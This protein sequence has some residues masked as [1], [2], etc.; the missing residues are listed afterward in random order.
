MAFLE[1]RGIDKRFGATVALHQAALSVNSGEVHALI[2]ENGSGKSTLMKVLAGVVKADGGEIT[3]DGQPYIP[4][5]PASARNA[6]ISMIHQEL[7]LCND[8]NVIENI[9]LGVERTTGVFLNQKEQLDIAIS[10]LA[11]LGQEEVNP[12]ARVGDLP[13]ATRQMIEIARSLAVG[14]QVLILDEPTS[15]LT[16]SDVSKLFALIESLKEQNLA[17]IYISHFFDEIN[18]ISDVFTVLRDGE[19]TGTGVT[20]DVPDEEIISMMVGREIED[21]YPHH[22]RTAGEAIMQIEGLQAVNGLNEATLTLH[23]GEVVGIAGLGGSGRT[24]FLRALFGLDKV[25]S[26]RIQL[27]GV[28]FRS[29]PHSCWESGVGILSEDR[30]EEGLAI[31]LTVAENTTLSS[32]PLWISPKE[33][34][35]ATQEQIESLS[36]KTTGPWQSVSSL[37]GGNQQKVALARLMHHDVD[38]FLL[39]EPTRGVD[40]G[41]KQQIYTLINQVA[42]QGKSVI[43]VSSYLPE[44]LGVCD[45]IAVMSKGK[46]GAAK[47]TSEWTQ[48]S[49]LKE[50]VGA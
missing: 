8:L 10:A 7:S 15:S 3:L 31:E 47:P 49:L 13:I 24:E 41:S 43:M 40:I 46:L 4:T 29:D 39:D 1:L 37:S 6:G 23:Q 33:E 28:A 44:L 48:E 45:R 18:H 9:I 17:I 50:A 21:L 19:I 32:V 26:G 14:C 22:S 25:T 12:Y 11:R 36:I 2:G 5:D 35:A 20:K 16:Q 27:V 42:T 30:K 34:A 38:I